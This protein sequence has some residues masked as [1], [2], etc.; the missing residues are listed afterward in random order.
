MTTATES[1][2][3]GS[4]ADYSGDHRCR[5]RAPAA[6]HTHGPWKLT[7]ESIEPNWHIITA[8]GGR[9][10]VNIHIEPGNAMDLANAALICASPDLLAVLSN[11]VGLAEMRGGK[12]HEYKAAIDEARGVIAKAKAADVAEQCQVPSASVGSTQS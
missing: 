2:R 8:P 11:L 6:I 1:K 7:Q 5:E 12:L 3:G 10:M 4:S 9:I